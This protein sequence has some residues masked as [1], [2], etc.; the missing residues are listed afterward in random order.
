MVKNKLQG[1]IRGQF[2]EVDDVNSFQFL[3]LLKIMYT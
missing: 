2:V 3:F 1:S